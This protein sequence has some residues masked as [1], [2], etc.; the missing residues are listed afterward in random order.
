MA[1]RIDGAIYEGL[2]SKGFGL[3][4][5]MVT[6]DKELS[7][8]AKAIYAYLS[9]FAGNNSESFP[10]VN[11]ICD[12][13]NIS[14][15]RYYKY[16]KSLLEKGYIRV[17]RERLDKGFSKNYYEI[18]Q[19]ISTK[20]E[21]S[22]YGQNVSVQNVSVQN[23]SKQNDG[24]NNSSITNSSITNNNN[25][26]INKPDK[27]ADIALPYDL[28][29]NYLNTMAGTNYRHTTKKTQQLIKARYAEGF[30]TE[31]FKKVIDVKT[32]GWLNDP[33][34]AQYLR[35]ETLF[36]TK[37]ESYLNEKVGGKHEAFSKQSTKEY[38][39]GVNF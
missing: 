28:I 2:L 33:R 10:S 21:N 36:G 9:A 5:R 39:D 34:W 6:R 4:P 15:K 32:K 23:V 19:Q 14:E 31:D 11:L 1:E 35:P 24:T 26:N 18:V 27:S 22:V 37:F 20:N 30:T 13:L 25:N 38:P 16:R 29:I 17:R 3:I 12:E 7:I 8:E